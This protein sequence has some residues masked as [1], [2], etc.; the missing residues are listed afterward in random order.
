[1]P[2]NKRRVGWPDTDPYPYR[3]LDTISS[4]PIS[5][6]SC[7]KMY[8]SWLEDDKKRGEEPDYE[9]CLDKALDKLNSMSIELQDARDHIQWLSNVGGET[10]T[11]ACGIDIACRDAVNKKRKEQKVANDQ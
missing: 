9:Y 2:T 8:K 3:K 5:D 6:C 11:V 4:Q 1:M 7:V 10:L